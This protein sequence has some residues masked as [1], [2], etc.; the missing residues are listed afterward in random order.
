MASSPTS[1]HASSSSAPFT[2]SKFDSLPI[3]V[4][5]DK[6]VEKIME[7][8]VTLIVGETGC[9]KTSQVP[10]F[11]REEGMVPIICTQPRRFAVV[12]VAKTVAQALQCDVGDEVGYHI[13]HSRVTS[14]RTKI[15]YKTAGV[16]LEEMRQN[17]LNALKYKVI[18]L[19]EVHERSIESDLALVCLKQFLLRKADIRL[20]LMSAT[21]DIS[22]YKDYFKDLGRGERVEVVAIPTSSQHSI[23]QREVLYLEQ[24]TELLEM[25]SDSSD[26]LSNQYCSG[27]SPLLASADIKPEVH[28]LMHDLVMYIHKNEPDI[29]KSI[30]VFLPTYYS[31]EQQWSL[32]KPF[33]SYFK[34]HILH[35]SIDTVLALAAMKIL[36]SHRKVIL[37]TN[38]AESSVTIPE[39]AYV[40]DSCRSLQ[41]YWDGNKKTEA[42]K[43]VWVSK[44][45]AD[46]RKGRTGRTCDGQ[47]YRMVTRS[48]FS[49]LEE[50][51][52]PAILKLSLRL[53]VLLIC[54]AE[55]KSINDPKA[56]LQK[57]LDSPDPEVVEDALNLLVNIKAI[58]K[59]QPRGRYEPTFYGRILS[60]FSLS[61]DASV[62]IVKFGTLGMLREGI[63]LGILMDTQPQPIVRP[64][65]QDDLFRVYTSCYY[66]VDDATSALT[67]R[68]EVLLM[69]NLCAYQFWQR[70]F[71]DKF[72]VEHLKKLLGVS[73]A[74]TNRVLLSKFEEEWCSFHNL[75]QPSLNQ[76]SEIYDEILS[77]LHLYRPRF[78]A[79]YSASPSYYEPYEFTHTCLQHYEQ[80]IEAIAF[81]E[82]HEHSKMKKCISTPFVTSHDFQIRTV[83]QK[84]ADIVKEIRVQNSEYLSGEQQENVVPASSYVEGAPLLCRFFAK[85]LCNRGYDCSYS[86]S[87]QAKPPVC[88]FFGSYRGCR[89]GDSCLFS[90]D[91]GSLPKLSSMAN[92]C[93][94]EDE[95]ATQGKLL[96]LF[97]AT[98][99]GC[100]LLVNDDD[101][102]FSENISMHYSAS[103]IIA[104]TSVS[105]T[106]VFNPSLSG[107]K[108]MWDFRNLNQTFIPSQDKEA[109]PWDQVK[110][111]LWFCDFQE[112]GDDI[113][114]QKRLVRNFFELLATLVV[115]DA[116]YEM[117]LV[118]TMK[119]IRFSQLQVEKLGRECFFFLKESFPFDETAFGE[120]RD[121]LHLKKSMVSSIAV[122]YVFS[123]H[124]PS[125]LQLTYP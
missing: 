76:I 60:S 107:V 75:V 59:T 8:R 4:M 49:N 46:Q 66:A 56:L 62:L 114:G 120:V 47:I 63:L 53:H 54:S 50:F 70:V 52:F 109:I 88:Q 1:S 111:V 113:D 116:L 14:P 58:N 16:L 79:S 64:F 5:R 31:L 83:A 57:A 39:V 20:V 118:L 26:S 22:R 36:K 73:E 89:N 33:S 34:V 41:V 91:M 61:F 45:Q 87:L 19:D 81:A 51:E 21:A 125:E 90:H 29:T 122:S 43:L 15:V 86:H 25:D 108:I 105:E 123:L 97:P 11:L 84:F 68:R 37:A 23:F 55:T 98:T 30:L 27:P 93:I 42:A 69:S 121:G 24:V 28:K 124:P 32:L 99:E 17:G 12:A 104:T 74:T 92:E 2:P 13:G 119:N 72:R 67:G 115:S 112:F 18:I 80:S 35:S 110:C 82:D 102:H 40:I 96:K 106:A 38:I 94:K 44:S 3:M 65:G 48:F 7:N 117:Q 9:G 85:G 10:L 100:I 6:I 103:K 71:K 77:T 95:N 101:L 78:L